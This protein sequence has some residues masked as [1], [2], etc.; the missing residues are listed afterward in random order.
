[1]VGLEPGSPARR[2]VK[3]LGPSSN[4]RTISNAHR[5]PT[6]S[7]ACAVPHPSKYSRVITTFSL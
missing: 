4:S 7:S 6:R 1:M 5:D 3:R 2:S